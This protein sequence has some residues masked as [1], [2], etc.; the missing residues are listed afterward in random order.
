MKILKILLGL[1]VLSFFGVIFFGVVMG[2]VKLLTINYLLEILIGICVL[3]LILVILIRV[4][5]TAIPKHKLF[6]INSND[7][8]KIPRLIS[9][10]ATHVESGKKQE[11]VECIYLKKTGDVI[12]T[13]G[14]KDTESIRFKVDKKE[15]KK[16]YTEGDT[17]NINCPDKSNHTGV[18]LTEFAPSNFIPSGEISDKVSGLRS[19]YLR[20][21]NELCGNFQYKSMIMLTK[22]AQSAS[23]LFFIS[24]F[25]LGV[26]VM[27]MLLLGMYVFL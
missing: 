6:S 25:G 26:G 24:G 27:I 4:K 20:C 19:A 9:K 18:F 21:Y 10:F 7:R 17:I 5:F 16:Q 14:Y 15:I 13:V 23:K 12:L 1:L 3:I 11:D 8:D 2:G 22:K